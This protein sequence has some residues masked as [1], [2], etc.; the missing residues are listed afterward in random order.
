[1]VMAA[2]LP[3]I[4]DLDPPPFPQDPEGE[5]Q[6]LSRN[7]QHLFQLQGPQAATF[8]ISA[9]GD[10]EKRQ[11][12]VDDLLVILV[13]PQGGPLPE[14][15]PLCAP[16][17]V[18]LCVEPGPLLCV[19]QDLVCGVDLPELVFVPGVGVVR[20]VALGQQPEDTFQRL[21]VGVLTDLQDFV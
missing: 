12:T 20:V 16:V 18:V 11:Y 6:V 21:G 14:D 15:L 10:V 9:P 2:C 19:G 3:R 7:A 8:R 1:M 13:T 4:Q 17:A 5:L